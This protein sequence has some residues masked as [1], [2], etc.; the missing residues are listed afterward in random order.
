MSD[1]EAAVSGDVARLTQLIFCIREYGS[2]TILLK[3]HTPD[4][5]GRCPLCRSIGCTIYTAAG[6]AAEQA[7][8]AGR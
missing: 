8:K 3:Q 2:A 1:D 7:R 6:I 5:K 4:A